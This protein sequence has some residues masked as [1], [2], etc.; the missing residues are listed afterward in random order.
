MLVATDELPNIKIVYEYTRKPD[1]CGQEFTARV[2]NRMSRIVRQGGPIA[3]ACQTNRREGRIEAVY[4]VTDMPPRLR[5][6]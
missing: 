3:I 6:G 1:E 5:L 4:P 2:S